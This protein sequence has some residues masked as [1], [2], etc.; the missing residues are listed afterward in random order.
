MLTPKG[1]YKVK[2]EKPKEIEFEEEALKLPEYAELK[3]L[4]N[5][6]HLH[7]CLLGIGRATHWINPTLS[8][9]EKQKV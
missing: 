9:E 2:D 4:D 1:L 8:E 6:V 7:P 3:V 5:W